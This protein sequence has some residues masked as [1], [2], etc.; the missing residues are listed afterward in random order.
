LLEVHREGRTVVRGFARVGGGTLLALCLLLTLPG[1]A[2]EA[3]PG[4][5]GPFDSWTDLVDRQYVDLT[6][7]APTAAQRTAAV[8]GLS[9]GTTTPGGLIATLRQSKDHQTSVD[10]VTRLYR[11]FL[12][13]I[14][15]KGGL[16]F[17]IKRRR[18]G[19]WTLNRI[20]DTF[21]ASS[22]FRSRYGNLSNL[23]F[24]KLIYDNV[25]ERPYDASGLS[26][27]TR[28]LDGKRKTRGA[29]MAN[30]SESGEYQ[31]KQ[32]A[33]VTV[34]V[35]SIALLGRAPAK[36]TFDQDVANLE[37]GQTVTAYADAIF[38]STAYANRI[39]SPVVIGTPTLPTLYA[40][41]PFQ[42][43]LSATGGFGIQRWSAT[44]LPSWLTLDAASGV[45]AG[46]PPAAGATSVSVR[47]TAGSEM[48]ATRTLSLS[49]QA[50]M[51]AGCV[52]TGC[53]KLSTASGTVQLPVAAVAGVTRSASG[54]VTGLSL[55][56]TAPAIATGN[57]LVV[58]PGSLAPSGMIVRVTSVTGTTGSARTVAV[59]P[60][61]LTE[62]Y[63]DG[64]V[65]NAGMAPVPDLQPDAATRAAPCSGGANVEITPEAA[66]DLKPNV[67]LLWGR[68]V[69]GFGDVFVGTGGVKLFQFDL[70]GN[71]TFRIKGSMTG[72]VDCKLDVPGV[73]IP[74][75]VGPAGFLFFK[76]QPNLGLKASAGIDIDTTVTVK[77]GIVYAYQQN[78]PEFRSQYCNPTYTAP[79]VSTAS[80]GADLTIS[81]GVTT[82]L[83]FNEAVGISGSLDASVHAGYKPLQNPIGVLDGKVTAKLTACLACA[84]GSGAPTLTILDKTI[85]SKTFATWSTPSAAPFPTIATTSLPSGKV[86]ASYAAGL[87]ASGG[88]PPYTWSAT[89][90]PPGLSTSGGSIV[91]T[92][93]THG[94]WTPKVTVRD[95][96]GLTRSK[97]FTLSVSALTGTASPTGSARLKYPTLTS[98]GQWL[99]L[100]RVSPDGFGAELIR[101]NRASGAEAVVP[102]STGLCDF[103]R[104]SENGR[105]IA[106]LD[107]SG[108]IRLADMQSGTSTVISSGPSGEVSMDGDGSVLAFTHYEEVPGS[109]CGQSIRVWT[110]SSG[111]T[112]TISPQSCLARRPLVSLDGSHVA[113]RSTEV[114]GGEDRV[115][116]WTR[117]SG[118]RTVVGVGDVSGIS[119]DGGRILVQRRIWS[120]STYREEQT[121][122]QASGSTVLASLPEDAGNVGLAPDGL[123]FAY[124]SWVTDPGDDE[125]GN[126]EL[127]LYDFR[128]GTSVRLS[129]NTNP[130]NLVGDGPASL[131]FDGSLLAV[132][133]YQTRFAGMSNPVTGVVLW[134][135]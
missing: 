34:S 38:S 58:A 39:A 53:A 78:Q 62:A 18:S 106:Y 1:V 71:L 20:A 8:A 125:D 28:Q 37:G 119:H 23:D 107:R 100:C 57:V 135:G 95:A 63:A 116:R 45:L 66:V 43:V 128:T 15:D 109:A 105:W 26:F 102:G 94:T 108:A 42:T 35:L 9:S 2:A 91:G 75:S 24:V 54:A 22:E 12:L 98:N 93:T 33:E 114:N 80:T 60:S 124:T 6:G 5:P 46:T 17:W 76:L 65:K 27:W 113:F 123:R 31:R 112:Q 40:G 129:D 88:R 19:S 131:S 51:P 59:T 77:C 13:R 85:W 130:T 117:S 120:G 67:T 56:A 79:K 70:F 4:S 16:D 74:I 47:V 73:T 11:A 103:A 121:L 30:F 10:P 55:A 84:F 99:A 72:S 50:G 96:D 64:I 133:V 3:E 92:P 118:N 44:G 83:T 111:Q 89:G 21:A 90:L 32:A 61:T 7:V 87:A 69:A 29:V 82:S 126:E 101:R 104:I 81:G 127:F 14:P 97:G 115:Y 49:V 36:E 52:D 41:V 110:R 122:W 25:L 86:G 68:N 48:T 132:S 134:S